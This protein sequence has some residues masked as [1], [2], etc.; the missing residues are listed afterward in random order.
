M[1]GL[2]VINGSAVNTEPINGGIELTPLEGGFATGVADTSGL[3]IRIRLLRADAAGSSTADGDLI[4][5]RGLIGSAAGTSQVA[6]KIRGIFI[7]KATAD[8]YA[9]PLGFIRKVIGLLQEIMLQRI[10][11][12][13]YLYQTAMSAVYPKVRYDPKTGLASTVA[14]DNAKPQSVTCNE[15]TSFFDVPDAFRRTDRRDRKT[16]NFEIAVMFTSEVAFE[17]FEDQMT[18]RPPFLSKDEEEGLRQVTFKLVSSEYQHPP[19]QAP[20][21]GSVGTFLFEAELQ[22]S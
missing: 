15:K 4:V 14:N 9:L 6:A 7:L 10:R 8:G 3:L 12:Q 16:W 18:L 1:A 21:G 11:I 17:T 22:R 20:N 19:R 5:L 13:N 2:G